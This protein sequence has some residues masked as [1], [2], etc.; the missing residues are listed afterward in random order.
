M[1]AVRRASTMWIGERCRGESICTTVND[2]GQG[3]GG[4]GGDEYIP[5][6]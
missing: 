1:K 4:E 3:R 2:V 5:E 6:S